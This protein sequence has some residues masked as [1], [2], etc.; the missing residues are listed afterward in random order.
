MLEHVNITVGERWEDDMTRFWYKV[1]SNIQSQ[2][3]HAQSQIP[4]T[5]Y[6]IP[7]IPYQ[8]LNTPYQMLNTKY[9]NGV[10]MLNTK[11]TNGA[12]HHTQYKMCVNGGETDLLL[13]MSELAWHFNFQ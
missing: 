3:H 12:L 5:P 1:R 9:T 2:I 8:L 13:Q 6:Q 4:N 11:Y 10:L 7:N